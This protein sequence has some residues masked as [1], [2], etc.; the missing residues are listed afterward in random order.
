M[1]KGTQSVSGWEAWNR[2]C[3]TLIQTR[4]LVPVLSLTS[5]VKLDTLID[6]GRQAFYL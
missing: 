5:H 2:V 6:R 1:N 3:F 4:G